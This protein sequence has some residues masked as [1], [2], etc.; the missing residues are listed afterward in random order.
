[1]RVCGKSG[2]QRKRFRMK[3]KKSDEIEN[4]KKIKRKSKKIKREDLYD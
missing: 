4:Q 3:S 2:M 1:M